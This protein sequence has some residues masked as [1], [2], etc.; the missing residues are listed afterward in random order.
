MVEMTPYYANTTMRAI[1]SDISGDL[2]GYDIAPVE[3]YVL[4]DNRS[5]WIDTDP[6]TG[7]DMTYLGYKRGSVSVGKNYDFEA[8]PFELYAVLESTVP[9]DQIFGGDDKNVTQQETKAVE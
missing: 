9:S 1:N 4:H 8:N 2:I 6:E 3:G 5:D 7:D